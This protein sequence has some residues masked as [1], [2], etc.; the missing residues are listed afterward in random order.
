VNWPVAVRVRW[1]HQVFTNSGNSCAYDGI[2]RYNT[3]ITSE[4]VVANP[5]LQRC[6][7]MPD[8]VA[9][10]SWSV[11][12]FGFIPMR[13]VYMIVPAGGKVPL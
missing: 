12:V 1:A 11:L 10:L 7:D 5:I 6:L 13:P 9:Y 8:N 4:H 2:R 3:S